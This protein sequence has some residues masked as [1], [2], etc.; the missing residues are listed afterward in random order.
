LVNAVRSRARG[1]QGALLVLHDLSLAAAACDRI[2]L[3]A[4][5]RIVA[6]GAPREV[7]IPRLLEQAYSTA[8]DVVTDPA[9]GLPLVAPRVQR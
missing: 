9:T 1:G 6:E 4:G 7:L 8:V 5:G 2:V 3:M